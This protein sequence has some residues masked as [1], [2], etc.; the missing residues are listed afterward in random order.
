MVV[1]NLEHLVLI[2]NVQN[3]LI[4]LHNHFAW[5]SQDQK[6]LRSAHWARSNEVYSR[7]AICGDRRRMLVE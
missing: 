3:L 7:R 2:L 6:P 4:Q 5:L 1:I